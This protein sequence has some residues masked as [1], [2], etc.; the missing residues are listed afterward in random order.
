MSDGQTTAGA[1]VSLKL[2]V[3]TQLLLLP[4]RSVAVQVRRMLALPLQ[5]ALPEAST[6]LMVATPP[7]TSVADAVPVRLVVGRSVHSRV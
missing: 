7:P 5:L 6:K 1:T 3:C 4:Q 2:M